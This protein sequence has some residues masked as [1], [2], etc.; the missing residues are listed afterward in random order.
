MGVFERYQ[1]GCRHRL[2][3]LGR[4]VVDVLEESWEYQAGWL[5]VFGVSGRTCICFVELH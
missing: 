4:A 5:Y 1:G 3:V 2:G